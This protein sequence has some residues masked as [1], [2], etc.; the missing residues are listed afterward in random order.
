M[1]ATQEGVMKIR[2]SRRLIKG[3]GLA[4]A[5]AALAAPSAQAVLPAEESGGLDFNQPRLYADD[6]H[7]PLASSTVSPQSR[8]YADDLHAQV[9]SSPVSPQSR[10]YADDLHAPV[11]SSP[12]S[13]R[14]D[15]VSESSKFDWRD[16]GIGAGITF[17]LLGFGATI[18]AAR[19]TRR[20]RL[21]AV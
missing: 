17:I 3:L 4:L 18:L 10:L 13:V 5:V 20:S 12:I 8:L 11:A 15:V 1:E 14:S 2:G 16:A 19:Q 7:A 21:A 9:A 6:L